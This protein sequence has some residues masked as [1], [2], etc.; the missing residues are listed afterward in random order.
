MKYYDK[1]G[2]INKQ[3]FKDRL[4]EIHN[5]V[6]GADLKTLLKIRAKLY[7]LKSKYEQ[8]GVRFL[9]CEYEIVAINEIIRE[10]QNERLDRK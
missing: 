10:C 7:R 1:H 3:A 4:E 6:D 5:E 9:S 8:C 2:Y